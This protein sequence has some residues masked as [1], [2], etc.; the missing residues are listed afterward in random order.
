MPGDPEEAARLERIRL[1]RAE[2]KSLRE[3]GE[4]LGLTHERIRQLL[5]GIRRAV[6]HCHC[7]CGAVMGRMKRYADGHIAS[8]APRSCKCG[9]GSPA[10]KYVQYAPGHRPRERPRFCKCGCGG[11]VVGLRWYLDGHRPRERA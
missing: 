1:L 11:Q 9:C 6:R 10:P 8:K 2:G 4:A 7:G 3:I 5:S